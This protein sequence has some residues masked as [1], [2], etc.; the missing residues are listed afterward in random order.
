MKRVRCILLLFLI[1]LLCAGCI[2]K[3]HNPNITVSSSNLDNIAPF[4]VGSVDL[5]TVNVWVENPTNVTFKNVEVQAN[6]MPTLLYCHSQSKTIDIPVLA[7]SEKSLQQISFSEFAN[8][9][10]EYSF[11]YDVVSDNKP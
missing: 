11:T 9:D 7:P 2:S 3:Y 8:L 1:M 4:N 10:C 5:Y 6:L